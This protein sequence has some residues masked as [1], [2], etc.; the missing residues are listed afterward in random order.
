MSIL[1]LMS[2]LILL[3]EVVVSNVILDLHQHRD[4]D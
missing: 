4:L 1:N 2:I 3:L